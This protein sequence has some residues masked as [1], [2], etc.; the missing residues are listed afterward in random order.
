MKLQV[1]G[2]LQVYIMMKDNKA[3]GV[4]F[5]DTEELVRPARSVLTLKPL[6]SIDPKDKG[7]GVLEEPEP[8]KKMTRSRFKDSQLNKRTLEE[9]QALYIKKQEIAANFIP[10][11]YEEDERLI[12]KMNKKAAGVHVEKVLKEPDSTKVEVK[13]EAAEQGTRKTYGKVLKMK[14]RKKARKPTHAEK[15]KQMKEAQ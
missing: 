11:G 14:A 2:S 4:V 13:Q 8:A 15:N 7:K 9:I 1:K 6:P 12:Q 5:K 3:K 10:I